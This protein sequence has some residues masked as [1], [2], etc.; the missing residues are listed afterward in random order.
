MVVPFQGDGGVSSLFVVIIVELIFV[1]G[2]FRVRSRIDTDGQIVP[3][4]FRR[5]LHGG[6]PGENRAGTDVDRHNVNRDFTLQGLS[7]FQCLPGPEVDPAG[8]LGKVNIGLSD[9]AHVFLMTVLLLV[10]PCIQ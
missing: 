6:P 10:L 3:F 5:V 8:T 7:A 9:F 4:L 1:K 2:K